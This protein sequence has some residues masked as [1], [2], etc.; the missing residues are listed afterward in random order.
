MKNLILV[1]AGIIVGGIAVYFL[2]PEKEIPNFTDWKVFPTSA[3]IARAMI[4]DFYRAKNSTTIDF[5]SLFRRSYRISANDVRK[6]LALDSDAA[7]SLRIYPAYKLDRK[8]KAM[9][10]FV[11]MAQNKDSKMIWKNNIPGVQDYIQDQFEPCPDD[12]GVSNELFLDW[13]P[14]EKSIF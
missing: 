1:L 7:D 3:D 6:L 14:V 5:K 4:T 9:I 12:C 10:S 13:K 8:G 2:K 11:L